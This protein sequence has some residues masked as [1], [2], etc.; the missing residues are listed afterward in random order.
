M[1]IVARLMLAVSLLLAPSAALAAAPMQDPGLPRCP[2]KGPITGAGFV[3]IGGIDQWLTIDGSSCDKPV[4]LFISGGPGNPMSPFSRAIYGG[5][6]KDFTIVQWDQRGAGMTFARNPGTVSSPLTMDRM[7]ADGIAV[8]QH[9]ARRLHTRKIFL[10]GG[11]WGS[12]LGVHMAKRRPDLF[13][14]YI[15]IAQIIR[16]PDNARASVAATRALA[17][18]AGDSKTV[19]TLDALGPLPWPNP[20]NFGILRRATRAYEAPRTDPAPAAWWVP[21][22]SYTTPTAQAAYE[23]GEEYSYLQFV[24][25]HGDG[26]LSAIDLPRLGRRFDLPVYLVQGSEDLVTVPALSKAYF[27][28]IV[29]P[30]KNYVLLQ[31]TGHDPNPAMENEVYCLL[32]AELR[33]SPRRRPAR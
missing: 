4:V 33:A 17:A 10:V 20:R 14:A 13:R 27:D 8:A 9:L 24:G 18:A 22:P 11:S 19:A 6:T 28:S 1:N 25:M 15:G 12:A 16:H 30:R 2:A 21:A 26:M 31:R 7:A 29:A 3:A 23:A 32:Q 5:W